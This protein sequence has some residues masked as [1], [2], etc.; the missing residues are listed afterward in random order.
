[1]DMDISHNEKTDKFYVVGIGASAGGYEAIEGFFKNMPPDSG[2]AFVIVQHLSPDFKSLMVELLS[3]HTQMEV[4]RVEDGMEVRP[5]CVYLIPPKKSMT[6]FH[7]HLYLTEINY[8][9]GLKLPIN[10]FFRSL[11]EDLQDKAI[12]VILSGTGS[13]GTLGIRDIK[14]AGG[15]IMVQDVV[16]SKF[17]GMPRSAISTGVVDYTLPPEKM[18]EA[19]IKFVSHLSSTQ[20][21]T[22]KLIEGGKVDSLTKILALIKRKKGFDFSPYKP[23]TILRRVEKRMGINQISRVD[24][25]IQFLQDSSHE[26]SILANELLINVT[27]FFREPEAFETLKESILPEIMENRKANVPIRVWVVGCSTG[28]EAY[29]LAIIFREYLEMF[30]EKIDVT[31]FATDIDRTSLAKASEGV[32][33]DNIIVDVSPERLSK[34]FVRR[35]QTFQINDSI[36]KM[37]IF[38]HQNILKDPP[39]NKIDLITCRNLLIYFESQAQQHVLSYLHFALNPGGFLFLGKSETVGAM[40]NNFKAINHKLKFFKKVGTKMLPLPNNRKF[41]IDKPAA[42]PA[43]TVQRRTQRDTFDTVYRSLMESYEPAAILVN[44]QN[45]VEFVFGNA[46]KYLRIP[47]GKIEKDLLRMLREDLAV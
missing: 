1:M 39:F 36:R 43:N 12:G 10:I 37:V 7:K 44:E 5:N 3:K 11:A 9:H 25:Y 30:D 47:R 6:V 28:E 45:H 41:T 20:A 40:L 22:G 24:D 19:L 17:D 35:G 23:S 29:S 21:D 4:L 46:S 15:M 32:Y 26:V 13:D 31:I 33:P 38:A 42:P 8:E 14:G 16:S 27:K 34:Y 2:M 18:P